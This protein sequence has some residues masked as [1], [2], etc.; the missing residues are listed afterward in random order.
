MHSPTTQRWAGLVA[1]MVL[2]L[3]GGCAGTVTQ[4]VRVRGDVSRLDG[5]NQVVALI[6]PEAANQQI[7]YSQFNRQELATR[8]R[9]RLESK[10]LAVP[11]ATH[12][13]EIVVTDL[14]IR[15]GFAAIMIGPLAG[16]D[17][18]TG[19]VRVLDPSGQPVRSFEIHA[20]YAFG[21]IAGGQDSV[22]LNWLY[23]KFADLAS[24][25][26]E[27]IVVMPPRRSAVAV[28]SERPTTAV[29]PIPSSAVAAAPTSPADIAID[30][31]DALPA[32]ER[33]RAIYRDWL[34][35]SK[36]RAFVISEDGYVYGTWTLRPFNVADPADPT[37][38]AMKHCANAGRPHC[39]L[40]AVDD[41]V[42][43]VKPVSTVTH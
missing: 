40:Y 13:V 43:Y 9:W 8:L 38:R 25:E 18:V 24:A 33:A 16:D 10:G 20:T 17:H 2:V 22:R 7:E 32:S 26:L 14:R 31:V 34:T 4:D 6:A 3:L 21:G 29:S 15:N 39:T 11:T 35:Q 28:P 36:P 19:R 37:A 5:V 42:V 41:R 1:L 27:K 12:Q 23:D 30:N